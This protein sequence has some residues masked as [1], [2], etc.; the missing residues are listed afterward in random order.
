[1]PLVSL[2]ERSADKYN[3]VVDEDLKQLSAIYAEGVQRLNRGA[4]LTMAELAEKRKTYQNAV[5]EGGEG[6]NPFDYQV[7]RESFEDAKKRLF[8]VEVA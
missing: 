4:L 6:F 5:N 1:V 7:S 2:L 3:Q 8:E